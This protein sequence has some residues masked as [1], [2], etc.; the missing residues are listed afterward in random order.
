MNQE[1]IWSGTLDPDIEIVSLSFDLPAGIS[2]AHLTLHVTRNGERHGDIKVLL[3]RTKEAR[4]VDLQ[5]P[6][7]AW[8]RGGDARAV[9][10]I[11]DHTYEKEEA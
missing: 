9:L 7:P 3:L 4:T 11:L 8:A 2:G 1:E 6:I 5:V 10:T